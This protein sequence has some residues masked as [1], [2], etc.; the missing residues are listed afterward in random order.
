MAQTLPQVRNTTRARPNGKVDEDDAAE[1]RALGIAPPE[2]T[3]DD[4]AAI[5]CARRVVVVVT[6]RRREPLEETAREIRA[7]RGDDVT[8]LVWPGACRARTCA[9]KGGMH[10]MR[11]RA[12]AALRSRVAMCVDAARCRARRPVSPAAR[13]R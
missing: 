12:F 3:E 4:A 11:R 2:R 9:S 6:G 8:T 1:M 10:P 13:P 5:N 7:A